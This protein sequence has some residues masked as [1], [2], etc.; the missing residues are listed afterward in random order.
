MPGTGRGIAIRQGRPEDLDSVV[1]LL[2][3]AY[4]RPRAWHATAVLENP[5]WIA[6]ESWLAV[7]GSRALAHVRVLDRRVRTHGVVLTVAGIA[8]VGT[9]PEA[10]RRGLAGRVLKAALGAA[11]ARGIPYALLW[12]RGGRLYLRQ[13][14]VQ[15][16]YTRTRLRLD[17]AAP[18]VAPFAPADLP[19]VMR[20]QRA[21]GPFERTAAEWES[22]LSLRSPDARFLVERPAG[23]AL[24][25]YV[26]AQRRPDGVVEL[27]DLAVLDGR[28]ALAR[29]LLAAAAG[30]G[31]VALE[32][33]LPRALREGL[34]E[35]TALEPLPAGDDLMGR[36]LD[37]A[38]VDRAIGG[39]AAGLD[40]AALAQE[41][42]RDLTPWPADRF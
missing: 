6:E 24:A 25:G 21:T 11:R 35:A 3:A 20:L 16:P 40:E 41:V 7:E 17:D 4:G 27:L 37:R 34:G 5:T 23:D 29:P 9:V 28:P 19:D 12:S 22:E 42:W 36:T 15:I 1:D 31:R 13:G 14:F 38:A 33:P 10:R 26:R 32:G 30:D 39:N 8:D 18:A 2:S